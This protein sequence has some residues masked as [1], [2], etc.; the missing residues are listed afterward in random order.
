MGRDEDVTDEQLELLERIYPDSFQGVT[1]E[2]YP[3]NAMNAMAHAERR[4]ARLT[5]VLSPL[6]SGMVRGS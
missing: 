4:P 3:L 6:A 2:R 5:R 1:T